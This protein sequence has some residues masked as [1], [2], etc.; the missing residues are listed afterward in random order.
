MS[1]N[2]QKVLLGKII[3]NNSYLRF[4]YIFIQELGVD[5]GLL[6]SELVSK[7]DFYRLQGTLVDGKWF[8]QTR[9]TIE[10]R[11]KWSE[12]KQRALL[13]VLEEGEYIETCFFPGEMPQKKYYAINTERVL[14]LLAKE[15][16]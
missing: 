5:C 11:F 15:E 10:K 12:F 1:D 3:G 6:L 4:Y 16:K 14:E 8:F 13:K 7:S 2:K 9:E